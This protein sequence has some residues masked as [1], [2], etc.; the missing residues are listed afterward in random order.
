M[1]CRSSLFIT[2]ALVIALAASGACSS[3]SEGNPDVGAA[4]DGSAPPVVPAGDAAAAD[5]TPDAPVS[6]E[7]G[8]PPFAA[9][10][11]SCRFVVDGTSYTGTQVAGSGGFGT[12][13]RAE[14]PKSGVTVQ[15]VQRIADV[16][17]T[18]QILVSGDV[19]APGSYTGVAAA[20]PGDVNIQVQYSAIADGQTPT[21][22]R[23]AK[24]AKLQILSFTD[25]SVAGSFDLAVTAGTAT[26]VITGGFNLTI[27]P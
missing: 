2:G 17:Y 7:S 11:G 4:A 8:P 14:E 26:K 16:D 21:F 9:P 13:A 23:Q 15:C 12:T 25:A 20:G 6:P 19:R 10:P 24:G 18:L 1:L 27:A 3:G 22:F 5:A